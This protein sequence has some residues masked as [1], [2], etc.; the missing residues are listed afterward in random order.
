M[1]F[2][3]CVFVNLCAC[4]FCLFVSLCFNVVVCLCACVF[5]LLC[6][7]VF[8]FFCVLFLYVSVLCVYMIVWLYVCVVVCLCTKKLKLSKINQNHFTIISRGHVNTFLCLG[9]MVQRFRVILDSFQ[10]FVFENI[11]DVFLT[12]YLLGANTLHIHIYI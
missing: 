2:V 6:L 4:V 10:F 5:L 1:W 11:F 8:K 3:V 9:M 7:L 12:V